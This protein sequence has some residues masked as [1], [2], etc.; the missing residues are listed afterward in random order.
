VSTWLVVTTGD[1]R[2]QYDTGLRRPPLLDDGT[3][4]GWLAAQPEYRPGSG[5]WCGATLTA[6]VYPDRR[7][8]PLRAV[9]FSV[10]RRGE[11]SEVEHERL[12]QRL[13]DLAGRLGG[14]LWDDDLED[15]V[16]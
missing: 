14:R 10:S 6:E 3:L 8:G 16:R 13:R 7:D 1:V 9:S 5:L 12:R 15:F 11:A 4:E 2:H